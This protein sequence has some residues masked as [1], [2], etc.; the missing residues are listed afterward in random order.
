MELKIDNLLKNVY[1][2]TLGQ[3][4]NDLAKQVV[5]I[6]DHYK[7]RLPKEEKLK[8]KELLELTKQTIL[9]YCGEGGIPFKYAKPIQACFGNVELESF[10]NKYLPE[11]LPE[12]RENQ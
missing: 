3:I 11:I 6:D 9:M 10:I 1:Y 12:L 2:G 7:K 4:T 5:E 8:K